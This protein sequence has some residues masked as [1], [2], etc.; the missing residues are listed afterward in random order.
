MAKDNEVLVEVRP[1]RIRTALILDGRMIEMIVED[2]DNP[3]LVGN[4][5]LGRVE[6]VIKSLN[7]CF[8]DVGLDRSG[9]LAMPELLPVGTKSTL[10]DSISKYVCEGD[11]VCVQ[12]QR[13]PFEGKGPKLTTRLM[14][15]SRSVILIP[16]DASIRISR[17]IGVAET[18]SR[19]KRLLNEIGELGEGFIARTAAMNIPNEEIV[20]HI[21][22]LRNEY[23]GIKANLKGGVT[24]TLL[25]GL[26]DSIKRTLRDRTPCEVSKIT[27]DDV[28]TFLKAKKFLKQHDPAL[29]NRLSLNTGPQALFGSEQ[30]ADDLEQALGS[31]VN[32]PSGGSV[33]FSETP[34]LIA[35]DVNVA[36]TSKGERE[37]SIL[38]TNLEACAEIA[39]QIRLRN[40]SGLLVVDFVSMK[41]QSSMKK[42]LSAIKQH[43]FDDPEQ[44][45]VA[46]FTRFG[47]VE[48]TRKRSR[49]SLRTSLSQN[50]SK[51]DGSGLSFTQQ[52]LG[53]K[54]L[55]QL[56]LEGLNCP[57]QC[58]EL[59][60]SK[61]VAACF[62][63]QLKV[64]LIDLQAELGIKL[65]INVDATREDES[66]DIIHHVPIKGDMY[67]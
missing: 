51:C 21:E 10:R 5:Y 66:F 28:P 29:L 27:L 9:F 15:I 17:H 48:M 8:V 54:V 42:V 56:R 35:I 30:L 24:P 49:P 23:L 57:S 18:R 41:S 38:E 36:G 1:G 40:L 32:L 61:S 37:R 26:T 39:R 4:I 6:K 63:G 25:H 59:R 7:A 64:A 45:F 50:C 12:V 34:A 65:K 16:D 55:D 62:G 52:T 22:N 33:I 46:G 13:D 47:L 43:V 58:L 14:L 3:S 31:S 53:F 67:V 19:L 11:K 44:V 2:E 20:S 60:A